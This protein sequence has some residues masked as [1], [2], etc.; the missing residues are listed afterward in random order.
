MSKRLTRIE[1]LARRKVIREI[2]LPRRLRDR[3]VIE[4]DRIVLVK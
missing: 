2:Q 4:K 3:V 1:I